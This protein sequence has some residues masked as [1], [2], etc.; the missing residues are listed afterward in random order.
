MVNRA[1]DFHS[2]P[3]ALVCQACRKVSAPIRQS[4][5]QPDS[6]VEDPAEYSLLNSVRNLMVIDIPS[7]AETPMRS[8]RGC[9]YAI[10]PIREAHLDHG[11]CCRSVWLC[12]FVI[13]LHEVGQW[14]SGILLLAMILTQY[15]ETLNTPKGMCA[16][17]WYI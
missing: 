9:Y 13:G 7:D 4:H 6:G 12:C 2:S 16:N 10:N 3:N 14:F 17:R 8:Y 5:F 15:S 1:E 11:N